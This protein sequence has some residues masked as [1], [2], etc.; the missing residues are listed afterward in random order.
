MG[1]ERRRVSRVIALEQLEGHYVP[2]DHV[3]K[4]PEASM[5]QA[6]KALMG[7]LVV[8]GARRAPTRKLKL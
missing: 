8:W 6:L 4:A 1:G 3:T 2:L 5:Y 7:G